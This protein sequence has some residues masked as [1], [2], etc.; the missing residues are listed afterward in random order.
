LSKKIREKLSQENITHS[1]NLTTNQM[2]S[3]EEIEYNPETGEILEEE[4]S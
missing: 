4:I 2:N 3:D 1:K